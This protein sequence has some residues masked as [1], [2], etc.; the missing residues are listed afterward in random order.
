MCAFF[1]AVTGVGVGVVVV[2]T[3]SLQTRPW[4]AILS[5]CLPP[6]AAGVCFAIACQRSTSTSSV[7][8]CRVTFIFFVVALLPT[9]TV[10]EVST[11]GKREVAC[12]KSQSV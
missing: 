8:L 4:E 10:D 3:N 12:A 5:S 6:R 2:T 1:V 9:T 7:L 11:K